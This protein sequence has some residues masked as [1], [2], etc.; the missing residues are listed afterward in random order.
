M[1]IKRKK[2]EFQKK[3]NQGKEKNV[4]MAVSAMALIP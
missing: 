1:K 2:R 4:V 3:K